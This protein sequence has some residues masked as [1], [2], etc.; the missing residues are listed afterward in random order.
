MPVNQNTLNVAL[1]MRL[2]GGRNQGVKHLLLVRV[3]PRPELVELRDERLAFGI[4][5]T[6]A[7]LP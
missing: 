1:L 5:R 6:S 2:G 7:E 4:V 3:E